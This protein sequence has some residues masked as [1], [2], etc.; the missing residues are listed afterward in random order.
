MHWLW[1]PER[2]LDLA[3]VSV[4]ALSGALAPMKDSCL[5]ADDCDVS[6]GNAGA[7][8]ALSELLRSMWPATDVPASFVC[9]CVCVSFTCF[10]A[11][12]RL[13]TILEGGHVGDKISTTSSSRLVLGSLA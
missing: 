10:F 9:V 4:L 11:T 6:D 5:W 13:R 1:P 8:N 12:P 2:T 3:Y 7:A